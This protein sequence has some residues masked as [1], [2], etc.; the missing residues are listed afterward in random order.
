MFSFLSPDSLGSVD[1]LRSK[2]QTFQDAVMSISAQRLWI[3]SFGTD[4]KGLLHFT[5]EGKKWFPADFLFKNPN[6]KSGFFQ[7]KLQNCWNLKKVA[8]S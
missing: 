1:N 5:Q 2:Q 4:F 3:K 8:K 6:T 7:N